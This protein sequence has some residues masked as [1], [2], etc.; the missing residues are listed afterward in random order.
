MN[1]TNNEYRLSPRKYFETDAGS[2]YGV[3]RMALGK[4]YM[5]DYQESFINTTDG[6]TTLQP[7]NYMY[8][9]Q[10]GYDFFQMSLYLID[11]LQEREIGVGTKYKYDPIPEGHC[12]INNQFSED[13]QL[14]EGDLLYQKLDIY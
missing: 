2:D 8:S 7:Y 5:D 11:T 9:G 10:I 4:V 12:I 13:I 1:V 3:L 14:G 6:L